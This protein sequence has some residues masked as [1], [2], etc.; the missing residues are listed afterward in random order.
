MARP[1]GHTSW[2]SLRAAAKVMDQRGLHSA[3]LVSDPWH[4]ARI[5]RMASD[6]GVQG[7]ASATWTSARHEVTRITEYA[8]E[9]FAYLYYRVFGGA[10]RSLRRRQGAFH[11][12]RGVVPADER[13]GAGGQV[14]LDVLG[15]GGVDGDVD[16]GAG[17]REG[18]G[19][20]GCVL[21]MRIVA[22]GCAVIVAG[23]NW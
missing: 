13:V 5:E 21:V 9:T 6:L 7:Y 14:E 18:V 10:A 19:G 12:L 2:E 8:R 16:G 11:A 20:A 22:P 1:V 4:N 3:F 23:V 15:R 17:D